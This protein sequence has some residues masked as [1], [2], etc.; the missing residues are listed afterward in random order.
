MKIVSMPGVGFHDNKVKYEDFAKYLGDNLNCESEMFYW[1]H[2][3]PLPEIKLPYSI[4][5]K[6]M[7]EVILDFQ[8]VV[9][10]AFDME[11]PKA[12][13]Y[14]GHS[15]G[16][17]IA[18]AQKDIPCVIFG[19][20]SCLVECVHN[21]KNECGDFNNR[22]LESIKSKKSIYNIVNRY[23]QLA[24]YLDSPNTEN[25]VYHGKKMDLK[26]YNPFTAHV[27]YWEDERVRNKIVKKIKSWQQNNT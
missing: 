16:S 11:V 2:D 13:Y 12:D 15:A 9:L 8:Q 1:K 5:R 25:W 22:L 10:H 21:S 26:T 4:L 17:I 18:L 6:W 27:E 7:Y 20:P 24:Y 19:S 23:D 14:I 3:W